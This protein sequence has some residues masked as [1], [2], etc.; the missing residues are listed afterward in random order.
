MPDI[1]TNAMHSMEASIRVATDITKMSKEVLLAVMKLIRDRLDRGEISLK[2][3]N[4]DA[5][6]NGVTLSSVSVPNKEA[7]AIIDDLRESGVTFAVKRE[8]EGIRLFF[9][10][11]STE[12]IKSALDAAI[13]KHSREQEQPSKETDA[14]QQEAPA[15]EDTSPETK[16]TES[17]QE[18]SAEG[19]TGPKQNEPPLDHQQ[20]K[21]RPA[22]EQEQSETTAEKKV[23]LYLYSASYARE[24][25]EVDAYRASMMENM[26]CRDAIDKAIQQ[27]YKDNHLAKG[28]SHE[29]IDRFGGQRVA[30]VLAA[31][32][33][34]NIRDGRISQ[35]NKEWATSEVPDPEENSYRYASHSHPGLLN[36][37]INEAREYIVQVK[38]HIQD[39]AGQVAQAVSA[40]PENA[41]IMREG[42]NTPSQDGAPTEEQ[43]APPAEKKATTEKTEK[44][45]PDEAEFQ[46]FEDLLDEGI[47]LSNE[48][49]AK[50]AKERPQPERR[51]PT[52]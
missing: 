46:P 17:E 4:R 7:Q 13:Q 12:V 52:R 36:L 32:V 20:E 18:Q 21:Q 23:P 40:F 19:Q 42:E 10:A 29:L 31:S 33:L 41:K 47:R 30:Y 50:Y 15:K 49:N 1:G 37:F 45:T 3:L 34:N 26:A 2:R 48:H 51:E 22:P 24:H 25:G 44:D 27:G 6:K 28:I 11:P 16:Q 14:P 39:K 43:A 38:E 35:K 5:A 9:Y 8:G